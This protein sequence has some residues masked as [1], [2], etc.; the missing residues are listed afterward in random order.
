MTR[1]IRRSK[2]QQQ[3]AKRKAERKKARKNGDGQKAGSIAIHSRLP[4]LEG[5]RIGAMDVIVDAR[6]K[7]RHPAHISVAIHQRG[8]GRAVIWSIETGFGG[9]TPRVGF[10]VV[11]DG[12]LD[13]LPPTRWFPDVD[14]VDP[15]AVIDV[16]AEENH[17]EVA[18]EK[19][20]PP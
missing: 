1:M 17:A 5:T 20:P 4:G 9:Q 16:I 19:G 18:V 3:K 13:D 12:S 15:G 11:P 14:S 10:Q 7:D 6:R 8:L 2:R